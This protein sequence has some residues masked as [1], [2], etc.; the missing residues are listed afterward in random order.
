MKF[1]LLSK[2]WIKIKIIISNF[3]VIS[4]WCCNFLDGLLPYRIKTPPPPPRA[5]PTFSALS[6]E[7]SSSPLLQLKIPN[8]EK[9]SVLQQRHRWALG[10]WL[11][12]GRSLTG[13]WPATRPSIPPKSPKSPRIPPSRKHRQ[14]SFPSVKKKQG[15]SRGN[16]GICIKK[17]KKS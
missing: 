2:S 17:R 11:Q 9:I 14:R 3:T 5:P 13:S 16:V 7:A 8:L 6:T 4:Y 15:T 12:N 10:T 1:P